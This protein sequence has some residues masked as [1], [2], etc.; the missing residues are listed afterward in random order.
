MEDALDCRIIQLPDD[1]P[2]TMSF[3]QRFTAALFLLLIA[4][5]VAAS[6]PN[7]GFIEDT[8]TSDS[9]W[10]NDAQYAGAITVTS[11]HTL[12]IVNS[13]I[14]V[15]FGE[16]GG[17]LTMI[18]EEGATLIV[19]NSTLDGRT[20][21][22]AISLYPG[23]TGRLTFDL[24]SAGQAGTLTL[25][26]PQGENLTDLEA[27]WAGVEESDNLSG[28]SYTITIPSNLSG[29]TDLVIEH[30]NTSFDAVSRQIASTR[31]LRGATDANTSA[32]ALRSGGQ[33]LV[34]TPTAFSIIAIGDVSMENSTL[35]AMDLRIHGDT[36]ISS[37]ELRASTP[38]HVYDR[39]SFT[40]SG[41]AMTGCKEYS[42]S[43]AA[44]VVH[45]GM[46]S[47]SNV[48]TEHVSIT[49][50]DLCKR[51]LRVLD[52]QTL[53]TSLPGAR[54]LL[55]GIS[56]LE[57]SYTLLAN[58]E[59]TVNVDRGSG[60]RSIIGWI[61]P[62]GVS[63]QED[64]TFNASWSTEWGVY[65]TVGSLGTN[66]T[67]GIDIPI[68]VPS[69]T[70]ITSAASSANTNSPLAVTITVSN[71][72]A[73]AGRFAIKCTVGGVDAQ[74][75]PRQ[76]HV[77]L[78]A[79][80]SKEIQVTWRNQVEGASYLDCRIVEP[81]EGMPL[82]QSLTG[83]G[84]SSATVSFSLDQGAL[85]DTN[86][87]MIIIALLIALVAAAVAGILIRKGEPPG[88]DISVHLTKTKDSEEE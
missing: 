52:T 15:D 58:S 41:G 51:S 67:L 38:I 23:Q 16:M 22:A 76:P 87:T 48:S 27:S 75:D 80:E 47:T 88:L 26:A 33:F 50:D 86:P 5:Y 21:G 36:T 7:S 42:A 10:D 37:T 64:A 14:A 43:Y 79:N 3:R 2:I 49:V 63:W 44:E 4:P 45:H 20:G 8:I 74:I 61:G 57:E 66:M 28:D 12:T 19:D 56:P 13:T 6:Q 65:S 82:G 24:G 60:Y 11:G 46:E 25:K 81:S 34:P 69:V 55:S 77:T 71:E 29:Q 17:A 59:G 39:G 18:I 84:T 53:S 72:G 1:C 35:L 83:S 32:D 40:M 62:T 73:A 70:S 31:I 54:V 85:D 9:V 78:Q 30:T 68:P